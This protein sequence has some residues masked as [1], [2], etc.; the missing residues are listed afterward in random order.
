MGATQSRSLNHRK[1]KRTQKNLSELTSWRKLIVFAHGNLK[2]GSFV[3][4]PNV[5]LV[6][7]THPGDLCLFPI[8]SWMLSRNDDFLND[9]IFQRATFAG[10]PVYSITYKPGDACP[11]LTLDFRFDGMPQGIWSAPVSWAFTK[12]RVE[13]V[14]E[15]VLRSA[16]YTENNAQ[17]DAGDAVSLPLSYVASTVIPR[18]AKNKPVVVFVSS[19]RFTNDT[20]MFRAAIAM[21]RKVLLEAP[22]RTKAHER[23]K[24]KREQNVFQYPTQP[25]GGS[26]YGVSSDIQRELTDELLVPCTTRRCLD[27]KLKSM[28]R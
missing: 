9:L 17:K 28:N 24:R 19:C 16:L 3:V 7:L 23:K 14:H 12:V 2:K 21:E 22:E 20:N 25:R 11:E 5:S 1:Q 8:D 6:F 4:P 26:E 13:N 27:K 15:S 10:R 18:L